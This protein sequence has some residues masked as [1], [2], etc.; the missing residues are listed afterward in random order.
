M[1]SE[2]EHQAPNAS[3]VHLADGVAYTTIDGAPAPFF[4]CTAYRAKLLTTACAKRWRQAQEAQG[5]AADSVSL[6][7]SCRIGA[8]HAGA[9]VVHYSSLY[10]SNICPRCGRG[11]ARRLI[12][13]R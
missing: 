12:S 8:A 5:Q 11:S 2:I 4:A 1:R 9:T 3:A 6:C 13:G 10:A 7:R